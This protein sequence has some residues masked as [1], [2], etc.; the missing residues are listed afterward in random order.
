MTIKSRDFIFL[1]F[2]TTGTVAAQSDIIEAGY[3]LYRAENSPEEQDF[4]IHEN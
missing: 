2:Q 4:H 3:G 1:D